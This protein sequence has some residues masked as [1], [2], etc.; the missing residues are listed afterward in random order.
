MVKFSYERRNSEMLAIR[1]DLEKQRL[2]TCPLDQVLS[3]RG[4]IMLSTE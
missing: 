1:I 4:A 3:I 2:L